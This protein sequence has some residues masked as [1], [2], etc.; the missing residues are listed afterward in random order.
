MRD[1]VWP[2]SARSSHSR[3][4]AF[5]AVFA[6]ALLL[7]AASSALGH[8]ADRIYWTNFDGPEPLTYADLSG[9]AV[10]PLSIAG[11]T[12]KVPNGV[13]IDPAGGRVYWANSTGSNISFANLDGSGGGVLDTAGAT[14]D[15][16]IGVAID[17][18]TR[19]I[20]WANQDGDKISFAK[21]DGSGGGDLNTTGA[22]VDFPTA[23]AIDPAEGRIYWS[24]GDNP[25]SIAYAALNGSGGADLPI[26]GSATLEYPLGLAIDQA[27]KTIYWTSD[28]AGKISVA[29][30]N[31]SDSHDLK[32][33]GAKVTN[34]YGLALD[35]ES[36]RIYWGNTVTESIGSALID[37]SG[38]ANL[39]LS[40][41]KGSAPNFPV[42]YE[43]PR[44]TEAPKL[45]ALPPKAGPKIKR[46]PHTPAPLPKL[47]GSRISCGA[48][49][50]APD[51]VESFLYRAPTSVAT[52]LTRENLA[53]AMQPADT[54]GDYRCQSV[55]T[56]VAGTTAATS[57]PLAI[58]ELAKARAN[59][60]M[61]TVKVILLLPEEPGA[62]GPIGKHVG[63]AVPSREETSGRTAITL[64]LTGRRRAKLAASGKLSSVVRLGFSP[65]GGGTSTLAVRV[66]FKR[67]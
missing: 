16:P 39:P 66:V 3:F 29:N 7:S 8:A 56:N 47:I 12:A 21:L 5:L 45:T 53:V 64:R 41:P 32:T 67:G 34:P 62:L 49:S 24:N 61:G 20:Y 4:P 27:A 6:C 58:F 17:P 36:G 31:G 14:V 1:T 37:G 18:A 48:G 51:L 42:L 15:L 50:F 63:V 57:P 35:P 30:L 22:T 13:A 65:S 23:V 52:S 40:I 33:N 2:V 44:V 11:T 9:G 19:L 28:N 46:K 59:R 25:G 60:R 54:P 38:G 55:G 43:T 26:S 10:T